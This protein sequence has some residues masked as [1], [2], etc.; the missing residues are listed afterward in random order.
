M[1]RPHELRSA[2]MSGRLKSLEGGIAYIAYEGTITGSH[3]INNAKDP[4]NTY[5]Y[6]GLP[7]GPIGNP[8]V[9]ALKATV[10]PD[11]TK[12]WLYFVSID[13]KKTD[14]ATTFAEHEK[15]VAARKKWQQEHHPS[16]N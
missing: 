2:I 7:P 15:L 16:G 13:D 12:R 10:N 8:G 4:Y 6:R 1:P 9:E 5:L 11:T 14:F 3:E